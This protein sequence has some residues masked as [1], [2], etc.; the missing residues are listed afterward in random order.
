MAQRQ[1]N[2]RRDYGVAVWPVLSF[3]E[4]FVELAVFGHGF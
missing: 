2:G 1:G 4:E 3:V